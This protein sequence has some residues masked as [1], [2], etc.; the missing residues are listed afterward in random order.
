MVAGALLIPIN[1]VPVSPVNDTCS[2]RPL[3]RR[4]H[5]NV[6]RRVL[7][8]FPP[9]I[10]GGQGVPYANG[11]VQTEFRRVAFLVRMQSFE[12]C[13]CVRHEGLDPFS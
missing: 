2:P 7:G 10:F 8:W 5:P 12:G 6:L 1:A 11:V 3:A 4:L 13:E 9:L